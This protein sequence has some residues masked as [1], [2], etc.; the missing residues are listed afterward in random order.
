[1][2]VMK[3]CVALAKDGRIEDA[4]DMLV[5]HYGEEHISHAIAW[6][7]RHSAFMDRWHQ[8]HEQALVE[9]RAERYYSCIPLLLM[10]IDGAVNDIDGNH[11]MASEGERRH[12][13]G[14]HRRA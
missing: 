9:Y 5:D 7:K 10:I 3:E 14:F 13:L 2:T 1:M 8:M 11:G 4:E 6:A 12:G